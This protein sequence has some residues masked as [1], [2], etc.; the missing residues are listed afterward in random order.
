VA[1]SKLTIEITETSLM[2]DPSLAI[3]ILGQLQQLGARVSVDDYGTGFASLAYLRSLPINELKL[4]RSFLAGIPGDGKTLSI[5][6]A[7]IEVGHALGLRIV[8][9]GVET[10]DALDLITSLGCDAAQ[11]YF[12]SRPAP[13][14]ELLHSLDGFPGL[15]D[16]HHLAQQRQTP[17]APRGSRPVDS[18]RTALEGHVP[19]PV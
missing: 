7:T 8:T 16:A 1:P 9:D 6:R 14:A 15:I 13:A 2:A 10:Q 11:G 18:H 19:P 5:V 4:D 3:K 12:I 17:P